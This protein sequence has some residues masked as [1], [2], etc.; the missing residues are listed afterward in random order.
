MCLAI[1]VQ[2][3]Q[4][5]DEFSA[6]AN[7]GGLKKEINIALVDDL[8]VGDYVILHVGFALKK[9]DEEEALRTLALFAEMG[10]DVPAELASDAELPGT[11]EV[12]S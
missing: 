1:P 10:I 6:I 5:H 11:G 8:Q 7:I 9:L 4:I 2:I 12:V 3:E